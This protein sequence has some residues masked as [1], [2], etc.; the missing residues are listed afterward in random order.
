MSVK[1]KCSFTTVQSQVQVFKRDCRSG[2]IRAMEMSFKN[3]DSNCPLSSLPD[4][5]KLLIFEMS[6]GFFVKC[7]LCDGCAGD[8]GY[9]MFGLTRFN[10][11]IILL[12]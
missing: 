7:D 8:G 10:L 12:F 1:E 9:F 11:E 6:E 3:S 2:Y 5:L 4:G